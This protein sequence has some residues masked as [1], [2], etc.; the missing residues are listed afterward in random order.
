MSVIVYL[1]DSRIFSSNAILI[2]LSQFNSVELEGLLLKAIVTVAKIGIY[3][4][5]F[6]VALM[7]SRCF[8]LVY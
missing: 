5:S 8:H 2:E 1:S 7:S 3:A 4:V 6:F